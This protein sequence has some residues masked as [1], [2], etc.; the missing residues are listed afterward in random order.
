MKRSVGVVGWTVLL[1]ALLAIPSLAFAFQVTGGAGTQTRNPYGQWFAGQEACAKEGCHSQ[2]AATPSPHSEMVKDIKTA[3]ASLIPAADS[4]NWPFL[5]AFGGVTLRPSDI[6]LQVGDGRGLLQYT[7]LTSS[8]LATGL[9]PADELPLWSPMEFLV[10]ENEWGTPTSALGNRTYVQSCAACHN[11]GVTRPSDTAYALANGGQQTPTTPSSVSALSIQCEVCHGTGKNPDGHKKGV[12][13]VV[14]GYQVLKS[15]VCGQCHVSGAA[16]E[17]GISGAAFG[18]PNG[19]TTDEPLSSFFTPFTAVESEQTFMNYVSKGGTKPRFLPNG[20]NYSLRHSYYNEWLNNKAVF[21]TGSYG[22]ANPVNSSAKGQAAN[23]NTKC[24]RC[25][26]GLGFL[27]RIGAKS[28]N[29]TRIVGTFPSLHDVV[30]NDPGISCQVCHTGHVGMGQ[31]GTYDSK[32]R[33]ASGKEVS[34]GDCHNW[35]FEALD[36]PLQRETIDGV[37][38]SRPA[39]NTVSRHPQREMF[40]GGKGGEDGTAGLWGV[41]PMGV[42]MSGT[43][44]E[45]CHMPR[46]AKEGT[47]ANDDGTDEATRMSHRFHVVLPGDAERYKLRPNGDSCS[48]KCHKNDASDYTRADMQAWID[49][50]QDGIA[51]QSA[52]T[53]TALNAAAARAGVKAWNSFIA[54]QPSTGTAATLSPATWAML[55]HSAQNVDFVIN[56]ASLG[57]HNPA[58]AFAGLKKAQMWAASTSAVVEAGFGTGSTTGEGMAVLGSVLGVGGAPVAAGPVV[59]EKATGASWEQVA[60]GKTNGAG[61]FSLLTGRI[62]GASE[63]RVRFAPSAGVDYYSV[64]LVV[65]APSAR[66]TVVPSTAASTWTDA[67]SAKVTI[68]A[69]TGARI[70]Y[71]LAGATVRPKTFYVNPITIT[72]EGRTLVRFWSSVDGKVEP[73]Q[74][75]PVMIDR[76][77]PTIHSDLARVYANK[78]LVHLWATDPGAGVAT[79]SY[80]FGG[81]RGDVTGSSLSLSSYLTGKHKLVVTATDAAGKTSS[82]AMTVWAKASP[83]LTM[84]PAETAKV[85]TGS[86]VTLAT[87]VTRGKGVDGADIAFGDRPIVLQRWDGR[88]WVTWTK[89]RTDKGVASKVVKLA[90]EGTTY[91]RWRVP[92]DDHSYAANSPVLKVVAQ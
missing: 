3:P 75:L 41:K 82:K 59:L 64:R 76:G 61:K 32:R 21:A 45:S 40:S 69:K 36:Q 44:C 87:L 60:S 2:I 35:Q 23:G 80:N 91:W 8:P 5:S 50:Q 33:W 15:Q 84:S 63:Y 19:Y 70:Y 42:F 74:Q 6:Y 16:S 34:C 62:T 90:S 52:V 39:A 88:A 14:G 46:T 85:T 29:G 13:G 1:A 81:K 10:G 53:T 20:A 9:K 24:L 43:T 49:Q 47:P 79:L 67:T 56:D 71:S 77:A 68:S 54:S 18:N 51:S 27:N 25:H 73:T 72:A 30:E 55:Q 78:A 92:A 17:K 37:T 4:G 28:P 83:I 7:G 89:T 26:S 65:A 12:P 66:A 57:I 31:D 38:Y 11:L 48:P 58:Y 86:S 22:H